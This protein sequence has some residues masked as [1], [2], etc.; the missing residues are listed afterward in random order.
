MLFKVH[1]VLV[2]FD[3][4][5][6]HTTLLREIV[7]AAIRVH[8]TLGPGFLEIIYVRALLSELRN[9]CLPIEREK[10]IKIIYGGQIIGKHCLDLVVDYTAIVEL[11][12][13]R[14]LIPIH[15]AQL[16]SYLQATDYPLGLLLNFGT[17][18]LQWELL[19][20][21]EVAEKTD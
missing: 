14:G 11:K 1:P 13:N 5:M 4:T 3:P 9:R 17:T 6:E 20:R 8:T 19:H 2:G 7:D 15:T 10:Q 18:S 21:E 12:A 16:R